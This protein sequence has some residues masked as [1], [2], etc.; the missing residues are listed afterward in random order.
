[1]LS[2]LANIPHDKL[3]H[4]W[5]GTLIYLVLTLLVPSFVALL[6][7]IAIA[8]SKEIYDSFHSKL[9]TA[10]TLDAVYTIFIPFIIHVRDTLWIG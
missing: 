9:H 4:S 5:Y 8:I 6:I 1:M 7:V 3:L 2:R 10:E